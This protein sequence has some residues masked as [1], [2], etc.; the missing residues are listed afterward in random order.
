[1]SRSPTF[2]G[3]RAQAE[4]VAASLPVLLLAAER[5]AASVAPGA[6]GQRRA[7][8]GEDFWQYRPAQ[9]SDPAGLIDWRRSARS[10]ARFVREREVQRAQAV[11]LWVDPAAGMNWRGA[12]RRPTKAD[13][14]RL[15]ALALGLVALRGGERVAALGQTP[16]PGRAQA[17]A[18]AVSLMQDQ[19][20]DAGAVQPRTR[21][22]LFSD[23]F[24]NSMGHEKFLEAVSAA[25]LSGVLV[26]ITD[27]DE[28]TFP[29]SGAIRFEASA[30]ASPAHLTRD[31]AGLRAAYLARLADHR[32]ALHDLAA[33]HGWR[34][35][36]HDTGAEPAPALARIMQALEG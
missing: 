21:L 23:F 22:V 16:R 18:L 34:F 2:A 3:F 32:A 15:L 10:D 1:M 9:D 33:R 25:G 17:D 35:E 8:T 29:Y 20:L 12:D 6:H 24:D 7:G 28:E 27:P 14:A 26:Q 11:Q 19:A 30:G 4:T 13:R 36:R 31:A 5:L